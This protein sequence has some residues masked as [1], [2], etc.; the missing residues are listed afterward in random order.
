MI[1]N[2]YVGRE[3]SYIKHMLLQAYLE[4]LFMII[5]QH[6][7]NIS[8]V[9]CFAGPWQEG[10]DDLKDTSIGVSLNIINKCQDS[11]RKLRK[12][13]NFRALYVEKKK[14]SFAKLKKY[15]RENTIEGIE[16]EAFNGDFYDLRHKILEWAG[17]KGFTFFFIDPKGWKRAIEI[18]TLR[19]LLQ[20]RNT[21]YLINFMYPFILRSYPQKKYSEDMKDIFGEVIDTKGMASEQREK[22]LISQYRYQVKAI[23]SQVGQKP[24]SAYVTILDPYKEQTKYH[25]M[26]FTRHPKGIVVFMEASEKLRLV[27]N[28]VRAETKQDR[29]IKK[30]KQRELFPARDTIDKPEIDLDSVKNY[31]LKRLTPTPK[32]FGVEE[33]ADMLEETNWF[34]NDFQIAFNELI[35]EGKVRNLSAKRRRPVNAVHFEKGELLERIM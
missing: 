22:F 14:K 21:E 35:D 29:R 20:R 1:Q 2:H 7:N 5:G 15:L 3:H 25:L 27:Q 24:R 28:V 12:N 31:W 11:L 33:L 30:T 10:S 17:A 9:D 13:V 26:Y 34:A 23:Q 19:P 18:P 6:E 4:R 16:T 32:K 8:Y